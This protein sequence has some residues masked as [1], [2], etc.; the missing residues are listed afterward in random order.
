MPDFFVLGDYV[1]GSSSMG[2]GAIRF[3]H[4]NPV[5]L[6]MEIIQM[7]VAHVGVILLCISPF[8]KLCVCFS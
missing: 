2:M 8:K 3:G 7:A 5:K 6:L 4:T 1:D